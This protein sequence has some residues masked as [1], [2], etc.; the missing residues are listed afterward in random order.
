MICLGRVSDAKF[1]IVSDAL[2]DEISCVI[3]ESVDGD[4][5][6]AHR[7]VIQRRSDARID[8]I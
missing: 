1:D 6:Y 3:E 7:G 8:L 2:R 4:V 5:E